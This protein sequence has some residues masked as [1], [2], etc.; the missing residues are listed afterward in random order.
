MSN[1]KDRGEADDYYQQAPPQTQPY[2]GDQRQYGGQQQQEQQ[3]GMQQQNYGQAPPQY[4]NNAYAPQNYEAQ[5]EKQDFNQAFKLDKPK[6]NDWYVNNIGNALH[7][8]FDPDH[9]PPF[10]HNPL[11]TT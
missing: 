7:G 1:S 11:L 3:Y 8:T 2:A 10:T 9:S 4:G 6:W 5:G